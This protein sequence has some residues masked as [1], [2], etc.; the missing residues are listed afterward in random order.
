MNSLE[1]LVLKWENTT[2]SMYL[3]GSLFHTRT[4]NV[5]NT[6]LNLLVMGGGLDASAHYNINRFFNGKIDDVRIYNR[7]LNEA[8]IQNLYHK[9]GW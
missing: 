3:N 6:V 2:L 1:I 5:F 9:G 4:L 7:V 8:E